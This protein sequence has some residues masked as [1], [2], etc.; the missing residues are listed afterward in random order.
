VIGDELGELRIDASSPR[1]R[2]LEA[3]RLRSEHASAITAEMRVQ[4]A[5]RLVEGMARPGCR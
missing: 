2:F 3:F 4:M 1:Q 5:A